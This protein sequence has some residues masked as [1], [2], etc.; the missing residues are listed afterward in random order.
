MKCACRWFALSS[1]QADGDAECRN[2]E[3]GCASLPV[4]EM[5]QNSRQTKP[6]VALQ[7]LGFQALF[8]KKSN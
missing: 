1:S 4:N 2:I 3:V 6:T 7:I 5:L 8:P